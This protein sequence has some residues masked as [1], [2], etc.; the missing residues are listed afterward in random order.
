M[1]NECHI[2]SCDCTWLNVFHILNFC[3]SNT[4]R[5]LSVL[6]FFGKSFVFAQISKISKTVLPCSSDLVTSQASRL[7]P[8]WPY[9]EG[10]HDSLAGQCP[11]HEKDL[12]NI[13]NFWV[14]KFSWLSLATWSRVEALVARCNQKVSWLPSRLPHGWTF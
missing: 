12:E 6:I 2:H 9:T 5:F 4:K 14:L 10:F 13:P 1:F 3:W 11:S 8:S 7:P